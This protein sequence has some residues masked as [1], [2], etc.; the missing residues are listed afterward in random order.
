MYCRHLVQLFLHLSCNSLA[1]IIAASVLLRQMFIWIFNCIKMLWTCPTVPT[2]VFFQYWAAFMIIKCKPVRRILQPGYRRGPCA[3]HMAWGYWSTGT[4]SLYLCLF[5][6]SQ[7]RASS[8]IKFHYL[9][10]S[11]IYRFSAKV[12]WTVETPK[13]HPCVLACCIELHC[14]ECRLA[15]VY[16]A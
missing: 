4:L 14:I 8:E 15:S 3:R 7:C 2:F 16:V 6:W 10:T 9:D 1:R 11:A 5:E 12:D 13:P